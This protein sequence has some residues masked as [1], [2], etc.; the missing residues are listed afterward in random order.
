M[1]RTDDSQDTGERFIRIVGS[2]RRPPPGSPPSPEAR[3]A[4][5]RMADYH[6]RAPK[7]VFLYRSHEE[8]NHD[9]DAWTVEA[10]VAAGSVND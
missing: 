7:G 8:A 4:M 6:T 3:E 10:I 5:T 2:R 9:R 1:D